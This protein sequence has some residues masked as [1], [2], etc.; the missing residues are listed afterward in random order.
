M[1][2]PKKAPASWGGFKKFKPSKPK[3]EADAGLKIARHKLLSG[4]RLKAREVA[5][6][7]R[8]AAK[9]NDAWRAKR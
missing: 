3:T 2:T 1:S 4:A 7:A 5:L 8:E 6:L 9:G